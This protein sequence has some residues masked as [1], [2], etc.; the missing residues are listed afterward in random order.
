MVLIPKERK[1]LKSPTAY[2]PLSMLNVDYKILATTLANGIDKII[3]ICVHKD[4]TGFIQRR[5]LKNNVR[6][7]W[8]I[9]NKAQT[10]TVEQMLLFLDSEKFFDRIEWQYTLGV[11]KK[12]NLGPSF[13]GWL[14]LL[15]QD[16]TAVI[17][18]DG[19]IS[20]MI[21]LEHGVRQGCLLSPLL[22][23]LAVELLAAI[24]HSHERIKGIHM[25]KVETMIVLYADDIMYFL[26]QPPQL[27]L[28]L[29]QTI[30]QFENISGYKINSDKSCFGGFN[31]SKLLQQS[32]SE[33]I[34]AGWPLDGI[35]YLGL[36]ICLHRDQ[37]IREY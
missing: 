14:Q 3:W 5:H 36:K 19:Q 29:D 13:L 22:F 33:I 11:A 34:P 23:A 20:E 6:K 1:D 28:H 32:I 26:E 24:I 8:N 15:Y 7:V 2:C 18:I 37:M 27:V 10:K 12:F 35:R 30:W 16:P 25:G 4:Q 31:I 17:R 9:I 21:K